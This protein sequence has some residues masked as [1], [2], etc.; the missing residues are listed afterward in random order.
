MPELP[1]VQT[2]CSVIGP[3]IAGRRIQK[4]QIYDHSIL[5]CDA[6]M[7]QREIQNQRFVSLDRHGKYLIFSLEGGKRLVMHLRMTGC[8]LATPCDFPER[9]HTRAVFIL[10]DDTQL[11][12]VDQRK[13]G[14]IVLLA[15]DETLPEL[16]KL[17]PE[18]FDAIVTAAWLQGKIG[19]SKRTIKDCLLDQTI[20]AGIGNIY[21]DEI[22]HSAKIYPGKAAM[23]LTA[24]E[25]E[26][27]VCAIPQVMAYFVEKNKISPE[28]YLQTGGQD[29]QNT[30]YLRVYGRAGKTCLAC[31]TILVKS[32]I[33]GRGSVFCPACQQYE[34]NV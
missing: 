2:V 11:R 12:F 7:F 29:Y 3:Q 18:P 21:S 19:A 16:K 8:L 13:F 28:K 6:Q 26:R 5:S 24:Q 14:K 22:L 20:I 34:V 23:S 27:L 1:E 4:V 25:Y 30:P 33:S 17:G 15:A 31:G 32:R 10:D 9:K